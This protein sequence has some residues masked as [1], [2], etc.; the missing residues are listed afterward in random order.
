MNKNNKKGKKNQCYGCSLQE[1]CKEAIKNGYKIY[2]NPKTKSCVVS[3]ETL[4]F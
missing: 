4:N 2:H 3:K 1:E